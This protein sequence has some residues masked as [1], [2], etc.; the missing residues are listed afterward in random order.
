MK[1]NR[2]G[3]LLKVRLMD[4]SL[5]IGLVLGFLL[6]LVS[7]LIEDTVRRRRDRRFIKEKVL[8]NLIVEAKQNK[9]IQ[10]ERSTWV[11]LTK[12]AWDEAKSSGVIRDLEGGLRTKLTDL[13]T[14]IIEKNELLVY[15]RIGVSMPE[16]KELGVKDATGKIVTPLSEIIVTLTRN[17]DND[18]DSII[19]LLEE[20]LKKLKP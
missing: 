17:L 19:P 18:I 9:K 3:R 8:K 10:K 7:F 14:K 6:G 15:H 11:S 4:I 12:D 2:N 13:Y 20:E 16:G 1:N 5:I